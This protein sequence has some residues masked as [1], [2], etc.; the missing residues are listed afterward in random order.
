M[1]TSKGSDIRWLDGSDIRW[2]DRRL[3]PSTTVRPGASGCN[4]STARSTKHGAGTMDSLTACDTIE[5]GG[6]AIV[7][8]RVSGVGSTRTAKFI[9]PSM[10]QL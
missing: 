6:A 4:S 7:A 9:V 8:P 2:L 10:P 1:Q 5:Q 3:A